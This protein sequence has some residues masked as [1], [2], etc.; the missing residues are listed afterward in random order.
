MALRRKWQASSFL[1]AIL[2]LVIGACAS[3]DEDHDAA[4]EGFVDSAR[5]D[6]TSDTSVGREAE[7]AV[8]PSPLEEFFGQQTSSTQEASEEDLLLRREIEQ[9][10]VEC[11]RDEGFEY[12]ARDPAANPSGIAAIHQLPPDE[13]A[14]RYGYGLTTIDAGV[15]A[16]QVSQ[17]DP[18]AAI[19]AGLSQIGRAHV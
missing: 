4:D 12:I 2:V 8:E 9:L 13:F 15:L 16:D 5:P 19:V 1:V 3:A 14:E 11:M 10:V 18:N 17:D 6:S 7:R